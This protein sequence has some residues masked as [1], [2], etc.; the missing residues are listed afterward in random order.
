LFSIFSYFIL[1]LPHLIQYEIYL[2]FLYLIY[3]LWKI[4]LLLLLEYMQG[5]GFFTVVPFNLVFFS[6]LNVWI[7]QNYGFNHNQWIAST[8]IIEFLEGSPQAIQ[9]I[10]VGF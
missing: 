6:I 4:S 9:L 2:L 7:W 10:Q 1:F 5:G 8:H 3:M